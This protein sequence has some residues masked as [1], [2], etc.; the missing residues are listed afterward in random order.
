[1]YVKYN[2]IFNIKIQYLS[3]TEDDAIVIID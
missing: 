3:R 1:M 2:H